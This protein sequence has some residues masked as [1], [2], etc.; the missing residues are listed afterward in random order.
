MSATESLVAQWLQRL[1]WLP[2][3]DA[4]CLIALGA[5]SWEVTRNLLDRYPHLGHTPGAVDQLATEA[6]EALN[7]LSWSDREGLLAEI[8]R[9]AG[10]AIQEHF[11]GRWQTAE[12]EQRRVLALFALAVRPEAGQLSSYDSDVPW[13]EIYMATFGTRPKRDVA[14]VIR[15]WGINR[16]E[17]KSRAG[18]RYYRYDWRWYDATRL[19]QWAGNWATF[20]DPQ[21]WIQELVAAEDVPRLVLLHL[22]RWLGWDRAADEPSRLK[23]SGLRTAFERMYPGQ[24]ELHAIERPGLAVRSGDELVARPGAPADI[25]KALEAAASRRVEPLVAAVD[26]A[27]EGLGVKLGKPVG[28]ERQWDSAALA[29]VGRVAASGTAV[30]IAI[31]PWIAWLEP[32]Q[33]RFDGVGLAHWMQTRQPIVVFTTQPLPNAVLRSLLADDQTRVAVV[34]APDASGVASVLRIGPIPALADELVQALQSAG[35]LVRDDS[36]AVCDRLFPAT[37]AA[38]SSFLWDFYNRE[39]LLAELVPSLGLSLP[40]NASKGD[41][42][43]SLIDLAG[44]RR[45]AEACGY[46]DPARFEE[47]APTGGAAATVVPSPAPA[48]AAGEAATLPVDAAHTTWVSRPSGAPSVPQTVL[49]AEG[50]PGI[51]GPPAPRVAARLGQGAELGGSNL[52]SLYAEVLRRKGWSEV[53]KLNFGPL[54][55]GEFDLVALSPQEALLVEV[56][57][58]DPFAAGG[59]DK[60]GMPQVYEFKGRVEQARKVR[61]TA[62]GD[63]NIRARM[64]SPKGFTPEAE[65]LAKEENIELV[66][67]PTLIRELLE[68]GVIGLRLHGAQYE[69]VGPAGDEGAVYFDPREGRFKVLG[70]DC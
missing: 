69:V 64:V 30:T 49:T 17:W 3:L 31:V 58:Y 42:I 48:T 1:D 19:L 27:A 35:W 68:T 43:N 11:E 18:H 55:G 70:A 65:T 39:E 13:D 5:E 6:G 52:E 7:Q 45:V 34:M 47:K 53:R 22:A 28:Y 67:A 61:P 37:R 23:T 16:L 51:P 29:W 14:A 38:L 8:K 2:A 4:L 56:K 10:V 59:T 33:G 41:L 44:E 24:F 21:G 32:P 15:W 12:D 25:Q 54:A 46:P 50:E 57:S 62:I 60:I 40:R 26:R 63:R 66:D 36:R 9:Q 20:P